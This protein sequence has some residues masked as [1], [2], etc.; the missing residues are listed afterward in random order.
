MWPSFR[1]LSSSIKSGWDA[2]NELGRVNHD[3]AEVATELD[4][5]S[6]CSVSE[7]HGHSALLLFPAFEASAVSDIQ[8]LATGSGQVAI[9][10]EV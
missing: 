6:E 7:L 2:L 3:R 9:D 4:D 1:S 5:A 8:V 10:Y